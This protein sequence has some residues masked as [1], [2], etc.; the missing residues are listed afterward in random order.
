MTRIGIV[1]ASHW[2]TP[3]HVEAF[4]G[5]GATIV[6]VQDD[7]ANVARGWGD[8]LGVAV[9]PTLESFAARSDLDLVIAMPKHNVVRPA[10]ESLI[11]AGLPFVVE[12]PAGAERFGA[13][14]PRR[15]G[16][17]EGTLHLGRVHQP[18]RLRSGT[19]SQTSRRPT[20]ARFRIVNGT[21]ARY[22]DDGVGWVVEPEHGGGPLRNIGSHTVEAFASIAVGEIEVVGAAMRSDLFD[23]DVDDHVIALLR[24]EAGTLGTIEAGYVHPERDGTDQE[25]TIAGPGYRITETDADLTV[26]TSAGSVTEPTASVA[27][28]YDIFAADTLRRL[29]DGQRPLTDLVD[30]KRVLELIDRVYARAAQQAFPA[31]QPIA[32]H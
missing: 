14:R 7:D 2:H 9:E 5:A 4:T 21:P 30:A 10:L 17:V 1:G 25:W 26:I 23:T 19:A 18:I 32:R 28:R 22:V 15:A 24:D 13:R 11:D 6:A 8:R 31:A 27:R 16:P 12:K 29:A 3:R 20:S